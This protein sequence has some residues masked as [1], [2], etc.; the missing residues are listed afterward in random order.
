MST[1]VALTPSARPAFEIADLRVRYGEARVLHGVHLAVPERSICAV[2]GP[3]GCGKSTLLRVLNRTLELATDAR[4]EA[5]RVA[6][7]GEDLLSPG[8][9]VRAIRKRV[10]L[11][12]QRPT[13]F[14]MSILENVLFG[15][16]FH[17]HWRGRR[18]GAVAEEAL[19]RAG[20]LDEVKERLR[21]PAAR[22]SVGQLQRLCIAR[23]LA[24]EPEA[25]LLDEPCAALDPVSTQRIE[26]T[27]LALA[28]RLPV[29]LVTH[30]VAQAR[31]IAGRAVVLIDGVVAAEGPTT[32][33]LGPSADPRIVDFVEG[34]SA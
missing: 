1:A 7:R 29:V 4:V 30:H 3:S 22:L 8:G 13:A 32:E 10:G 27:L 28:E 2:L 18:P 17:R 21:E 25:L 14:P 12:P 33:V 16:R 26:A 19:A 34:R 5:R 11:I 15:V 23:T 24:N 20:L 6:F 31:R 9:D